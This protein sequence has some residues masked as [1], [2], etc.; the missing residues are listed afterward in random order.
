MKE[1]EA[2]TLIEMLN[3]KEVDK[4]VGA[5][6][7][8]GRRDGFGGLSFP[9]VPS[10]SPPPQWA[11]IY[12]FVWRGNTCLQ[13]P[14]HH[15]DLSLPYINKVYDPDLNVPLLLIVLHS[16]GKKRE[17]ERM[18]GNSGQAVDQHPYEFV[19]VVWHHERVHKSIDFSYPFSAL[20][21]KL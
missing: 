17:R 15:K 21:S 5:F 8:K 18:E 2:G 10:I 19:F 16:H 7:L 14:L 13:K 1:R 9:V 4:I 11:L 6:L 12:L 3:K 20:C